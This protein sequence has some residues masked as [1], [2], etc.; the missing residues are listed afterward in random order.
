M[1]NVT[2]WIVLGVVALISIVVISNVVATR[3]KEVDMRELVEAQ[4]QTCEANFDK[5]YKTVSQ[6]AQIPEEFTEKSK[7]A[8]KEIY[9][10]LMEGRYQN[11]RGG[12]LMSWVTEQNPQYDMA[13]LQ[14]LYMKLANAIE[15]NRAEYFIEQKKLIDYS[16]EHSAM[17]KKFPGYLWLAD[18]EEIEITIITSA[19]TEDVYKTG[20]ENDITLFD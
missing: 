14:E 13:A 3:N 20:Q 15:A 6:L 18:K 7:E 9:P 5:M 16:R 4:Q 19:Y 1:K 17:L 10:A 2:L 8:F 12:A 11:D